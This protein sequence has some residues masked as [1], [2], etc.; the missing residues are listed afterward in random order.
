MA[1]GAAAATGDV[2]VAVAVVEA[3]V[4]AGAAA[5]AAG[6]AVAAVVAVVIGAGDRPTV[7]SV[8]IHFFLEL[9]CATVMIG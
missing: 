6:V 5:V 7:Q 9:I 3:A 2:G 8:H 1:V 4:A